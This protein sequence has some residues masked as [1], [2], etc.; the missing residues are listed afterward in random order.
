VPTTNV[1]TTNVPTT[2]VPTTN[3]PTTNVPTTKWTLLN[4][5]SAKELEKIENLLL[6]KCLITD[7]SD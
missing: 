6:N 5:Q 7:S 2:N 3:V 1:P 4:K